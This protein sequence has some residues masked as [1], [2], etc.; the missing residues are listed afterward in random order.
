MYVCLPQVF[1]KDLSD[2]TFLTVSLISVIK[3]NWLKLYFCSQRL[4]FSLHESLSG[5]RPHLPLSWIHLRAV[6]SSL[7]AGSSHRLMTLQW[8]MCILCWFFKG[9]HTAYIEC[10]FSRHDSGSSPVHGPHSKDFCKEPDIFSEDTFQSAKGGQR[11]KE[12]DVKETT[13][14]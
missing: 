6:R 12:E 4:H 3:N 7:L 5:L 1:M 2:P 13:N 9:E 10:L 14:F 8:T 11:R